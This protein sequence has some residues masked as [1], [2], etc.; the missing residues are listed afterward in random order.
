MAVG[1]GAFYGGLQ[2]AKASG[3]TARAAGGRMGT[4]AQR[5]GGP[6]GAPGGQVRVFGGGTTGEILSKDDASMTLKLMDGGSKIVFFSASTTVGKM[7]SGT[8]EDLTQGTNVIVM[9]N[10]NSDGSVT[11]SQIQIRPLLERQP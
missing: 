8:L 6:I 9:G 3:P 2:Y 1:G 5:T 11:A 7:T 4:F 10:A